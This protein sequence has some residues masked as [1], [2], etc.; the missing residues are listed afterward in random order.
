MV[1]FAA[2]LPASA[3]GSICDRL[4]EITAN[5][6][7]TKNPFANSRM[8][9]QTS[10]HHSLMRITVQGR[11][12]GEAHPVDASPIHSLDAEGACVDRHRVADHGEATE[13]AHQE[14]AD[15]L[16]GSVLRHGDPRA[17]EQFVWPQHAGKSQ[18]VAR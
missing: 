13:L 17:F 18:P 15:G 5:S 16:V 7:A 1:V 14:A 9:S 6:A 3:L 8:T 2:R 11:R 4:A 12:R 10:P